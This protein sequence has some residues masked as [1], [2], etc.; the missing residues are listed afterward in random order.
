[1]LSLICEKW[2]FECNQIFFYINQ[3]ALRAE[4]I[5]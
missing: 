5:A 2:I 1:M 4:P 3:Q